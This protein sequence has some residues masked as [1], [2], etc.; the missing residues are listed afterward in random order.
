MLIV[1]SAVRL[2][3]LRGLALLL[4]ISLGAVG[5]QGR[6]GH[7]ESIGSALE[8][9]AEELRAKR[10]SEGEVEVYSGEAGPWIVVVV[11]LTGVDYEALLRSGLSSEAVDRLEAQGDT[12]RNGQFLV[13]IRRD[14]VLTRPLA[15]DV[16]R[17]DRQFVLSGGE[18]THV[19]AKL[20]GATPEGRP[21]LVDMFTKEP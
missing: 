10:G 21:S 17:V 18:T 9:N 15:V 13:Q 2:Q 19:V 16:I 6:T 5:C 12:L 8:R 20:K 11:P 7:L 1:Q 3:F 4:V 14:A